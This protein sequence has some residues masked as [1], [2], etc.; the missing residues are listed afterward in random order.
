MLCRL[1]D[2]NEATSRRTRMTLPDKR[3]LRH[4]AE[5]CRVMAEIYRDPETRRLILEIA[6]E[7]DRMAAQAATLEIQLQEL[8]ASEPIE[9][10]HQH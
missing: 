6:N 10:N 4:R 5:E 7:F 8:A 2:I 1:P 9:R 3:A